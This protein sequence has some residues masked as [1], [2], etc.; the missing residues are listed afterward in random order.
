[1]PLVRQD[2][3][4]SCRL[5]EWTPKKIYEEFNWVNLRPA[6]I[7]NNHIMLF[8]SLG[9]LNEDEMLEFFITNR[10]SDTKILTDE[11][12]EH[13][14]QASSGATTGDWLLFL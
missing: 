3:N 12:F 2:S 8:C 13:L 5:H 9:A 4:I 1:M 11:N 14:T 7:G 10:E 6:A